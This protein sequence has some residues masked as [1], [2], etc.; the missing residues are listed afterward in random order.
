MRNFK[1]ILGVALALV[2]VLG[3]FSVTAVA[4]EPVAKVNGTS[5]SSVQAAIDAAA[6][7]DTVKL[8][9]DVKEDVVISK[10]ITLDGSGPNKSFE[11][12]ITITKAKDVTIQ[13]IKFF[14]SYIVKESSTRCDLTV[15][16]CTF[17]GALGSSYAMK[18]GYIDNLVI[19]NCLAKDVGIGFVY[20]YKS[21]D[22]ISVKD[23]T[24]NGATYAFHVAYANDCFFE[25]VTVLNATYGYAFQAYGAKNISFKNCSTEAKKAAINVVAR[26]K[27]MQTIYNIGDNNFGENGFEFPGQEDYVTVIR[28]PYVFAIGETKYFTLNDAAAAAVD[29]D[30]ITVIEDYEFDAAAA[31]EVD[32]WYSFGHVVDKKIT[33]DLNGKT[34]KFNGNTP[35]VVLGVVSV[36]G[37]GDVTLVDSSEAQTGALELTAGDAGVYSLLCTYE[38]E[39]KLTVESGRYATDKVKEGWSL[40]YSSGSEKVTVNGGD[41]Y[42]GNADYDYWWTNNPELYAWIFNAHGDGMKVINVTGGTYNADP[43]HYHGEVKYP[44]CIGPVEIAEDVWEVTDSHTPGAPATCQVAQTCTVCGAELEGIKACEFV[45]YVES[46]AATCYADAT[47]TAECIY[48]CGRTHTIAVEGT[49]LNHADADGDKCCD[50]C[51]SDYCSICGKIHESFLAD[52]ICLLTELFNLITSFVKSAF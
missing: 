22:K 46:S 26:N 28:I 18:L 29:G 13:G 8:I 42:L 43:T 19:E 34:L 5:Y 2:M 48:G 3:M 30:V 37:T 36:D 31:V 32:G 40:I 45:D 10:N 15:K 24:V 11:G 7:G 49:R 25:N 9:A 21:S 12:K 17:S 33:I 27:A 6:A 23:V 4:A 47:M 44:T 1:R 16:N 35:D 51:G 38:D 14:D 41:F 52:I 50:S 20:M 39:A